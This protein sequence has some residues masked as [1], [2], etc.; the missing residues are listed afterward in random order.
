MSNFQIG[1]R[2][3]RVKSRLIGSSGAILRDIGDIVTVTGL[4]ESHGCSV[5]EYVARNGYPTYCPSDHYVLHERVERLVNLNGPFVTGDV[6]EARDGEASEWLTPGRRYTVAEVIKGNAL[7]TWGGSVMIVD[8]KGG[9]PGWH[10]AS[11]LRL[12]IPAGG[13]KAGDLVE[14]LRADRKDSTAGK[15]YV[16]TEPHDRYVMMNCDDGDPGAFLLPDFRI[17]SRPDVN[18]WHAWTGGDNPVPGMWVEVRGSLN[19]VQYMGASD[20]LIWTAGIMAPITGFRIVEKPVAIIPDWREFYVERPWPS[21]YQGAPIIFTGC[22]VAPT[23]PTP[24]PIGL[25]S[26]HPGD[27]ITLRATVHSKDADGDLIPTLADGSAGKIAFTAD[28]I[29]THTPRLKVGD[30]VT[31]GCDEGKIVF[32]SRQKAIVDYGDVI[33]LEIEHLD[34]LDRAA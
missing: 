20:G 7:N 32:L 23:I 21:P 24:E 34:D 28:D 27:E 15:R 2:V 25:A 9:R 18:G 6:V 30:D 8:D 14:C 10:F 26:I 4:R 5:V 33:G 12:A 3:R 17:I 1:D 31:N 22:S 13:F 29:L 16:V 11:R 19:D